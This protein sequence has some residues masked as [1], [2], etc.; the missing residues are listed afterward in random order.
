MISRL[1]QQ[2]SHDGY[3]PIAQTAGDV[4]AG[5]LV[6][7]SLVAEPDARREAEMKRL[8]RSSQ[9]A[10]EAELQSEEQLL[11]VTRPSNWGVIVEDVVWMIVIAGL[12]LYLDATEYTN[13]FVWWTFIFAMI[14]IVLGMDLILQIHV[15]VVFTNKRLLVITPRLVCWSR[16]WSRLYKSMSDIEVRYDD[17]RTEGTIKFTC[18]RQH[19]V[20]HEVLRSLKRIPEIHTILTKYCT[21][22][23]MLDANRTDDMLNMADAQI[24]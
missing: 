7:N 20:H 8:P 3:A 5:D 17:N 4:E 16:V 24:S 18:K 13:S 2:F 12:I 1:V 6:D 22:A 11:L 23:Q 15:F 14:E 21:N 19:T 10:L 9:K